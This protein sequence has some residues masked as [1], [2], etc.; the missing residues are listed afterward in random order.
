MSRYCSDLLSLKVTQSHI[1]WTH[2]QARTHLWK[3]GSLAF[4]PLS[5]TYC[6]YLDTFERYSYP[7]FEHTGE[8][9]NGCHLR[10][11]KLF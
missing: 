2:I 7:G 4:Y 11:A 8:R 3:F 9:I 6:P 10:N 1:N 5:N